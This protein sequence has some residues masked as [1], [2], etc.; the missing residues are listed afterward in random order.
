M[1]YIIPFRVVRK[2]Q[3]N[4]IRRVAELMGTPVAAQ[5]WAQLNLDH[6]HTGLLSTATQANISFTLKFV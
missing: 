4:R 6:T 1:S 2:V 3:C 5:L